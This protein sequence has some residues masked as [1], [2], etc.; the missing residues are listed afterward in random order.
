MKMF[1]KIATTVATLAG[2]VFLVG[3]I[4]KRKMKQQQLHL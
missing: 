3:I 1:L 4:R 2:L